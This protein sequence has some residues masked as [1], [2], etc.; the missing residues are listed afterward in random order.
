MQNAVRVPNGPLNSNE[1]AGG[2][3]ASEIGKGRGLFLAQ[4]CSSCHGGGLWSTSVKNFTS[5]P[6]GNLIDCEVDLGAAA[7]PGSFCNK[8]PVFGNPVAVQYLN[9]FLK[10]V[11]SFNLGVTGQGNPIGSNVGAVEK[12]APALVNGVSQPPQDAL[13]RDY[14]QDGRGLGYNVQSLLGILAAQPYMHNGACKSIACVVADV[15]HRTGNGHL[16]DKLQ[17]PADQKAIVRFVESIDAQTPPF[18]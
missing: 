9:A 8:P 3:S 7:P 10:N 13:G 14:N 6:A 15:D 1:I 5:P 18:N 4:Q 2:V 16:P 17:D 12:A 11:G